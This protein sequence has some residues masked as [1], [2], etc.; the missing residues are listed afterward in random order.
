MKGKLVNVAVLGID[1]SII[2]GYEPIFPVRGADEVNFFLLG[3]M[4]SHIVTYLILVH[5]LHLI[6]IGN[7]V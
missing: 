5:F 7:F 2:V 6:E 4:P 3:V 1:R